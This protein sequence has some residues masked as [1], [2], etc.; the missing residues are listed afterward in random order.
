VTA[1]DAAQAEHAATALEGHVDLILSDLHLGDGPDGLEAI[2]EVRRL[3]GRD[4]P[5]VLVTGDTAQAEIQRVTASGYPVLF[6]PVQPRRLFE[7]LRNVL[8]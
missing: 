1:A 7:A 5:A 6:K 8:S 2:A 3:C 4:V